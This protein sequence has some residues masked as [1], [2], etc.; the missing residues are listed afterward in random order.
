MERLVAQLVAGHGGASLQSERLPGQQ[1]PERQLFE[2]GGGRSF[3]QGKFVEPPPDVA[4]VAAADQGPA[5]ADGHDVVQ[6]A[7]ARGCSPGFDRAQGDGACRLRETAVGEGTA[8]AAGRG[9][10]TVEGSELHD[11]L[12]VVGRMAAV[13]QFVGQGREGASAGR[14]VDGEIQIEQP[15]IDAVDIAVDHGPRLVARERTDGG[16]GVVAYAGQGADVGI[17]G[18]KAS[19]EPLDDL[20][21]RRVQVSGPGVV[22][23]PLPELHDPILGS[24][25]QLGDRGECL[26][27]TVV[28]GGALSDARL[29]EDGLREPDPVGVARPA[30]HQVAFVGFVPGPK[31]GAQ[32]IVHTCVQNYALSGN[33]TTPGPRTGG[34]IAPLR[35]SISVDRHARSRRTCAPRRRSAP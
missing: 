14:R 1:L 3:D 2:V 13:Q 35:S 19:A 8:V 17:S 20:P 22:S 25:G 28:V 18:G 11:G 4:A 15:R 21:C 12:I 16:G 34:G 33:K 29:L 30:P 31:R 7:V 26:Q 10:R 9:R 24:C 5:V 23:Q 6:I 27:K 32:R